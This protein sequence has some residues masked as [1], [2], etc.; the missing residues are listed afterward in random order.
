M[1]GFCGNGKEREKGLNRGSSQQREGVAGN[2]KK[3]GSHPAGSTEGTV[4][5]AF[6]TR[7]HS[8]EKR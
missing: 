7:P 3:R 8:L 4:A 2:G 1:K 5:I 6:G